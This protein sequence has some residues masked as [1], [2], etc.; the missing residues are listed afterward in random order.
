M[1]E[2]KELPLTKPSN[3]VQQSNQTNGGAI[4]NQ[5][6][7]TSSQGQPIVIASTE[8][9]CN[10]NRESSEA[11]DNQWMTMKDIWP[12]YVNLMPNSQHV[13]VYGCKMCPETFPK[14]IEVSDMFS[15]E[16]YE[17]HVGISP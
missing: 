14:R 5:P 10:E 7:D 6:E 8:S 13:Q 1:K 9:L 17:N 16:S 2:G 3:N 15:K 4:S 12:K 11:A